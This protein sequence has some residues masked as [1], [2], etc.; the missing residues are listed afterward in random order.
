MTFLVHAALTERLGCHFR[1]SKSRLVSLA[2]L[3]I[4]VA[5][6]RTVNLSHLAVFLP[7]FALQAS[8]YRRLQR[9]FQFVR[10]D[11]DRMAAL[12]VQMLDLGRPKCLA[13]D[14]TNWQIG[15]AH[16]N[17]L[18][19]AIVTR[20]FRIP[21]L[22]TLL[23]GKG[24]SDTACRIALIKRYLAL[25]DASSITML[26]AD[27]EFIGAQWIEFLNENNIKFV[28]R[29]RSDLSLTFKNGDT[30]SFATLL[31]NRRARKVLATG[32][33]Y[34]SA[35][36]ERSRHLLRY[37]AKQLA[38]DEWLIVITN[39]MDAKRALNDYR[40][41]WAIECLFGDAKTRGLNLEDTHMRSPEKLSCLLVIATLA[42]VW[43]YRCA[44]KT[45]GMKAIKRKAH[46]RREKSWFRLGLDT[47]RRW[48]ANHSE[49]AAI[50]FNTPLHSMH[51]KLILKG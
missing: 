25:F 29:V 1:L 14:R 44:S 13:L 18:V 21:L 17:I 15:S 8:N 45:M 40:K 22:W 27:R 34:L 50:A 47:L 19:L 20:R 51:R 42:M 32:E 10:L 35:T 9:F 38:C 11:T 43:A 26:L 6:S 3:I 41:R 5:Q 2:I 46:G 36:D 4:G 23:P 37:A 7:G 30:W 31:H 33:G 12:V 48:I 28:I 39:R 16:V 49:N 24:N